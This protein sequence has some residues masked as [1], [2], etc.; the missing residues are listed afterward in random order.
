MR[1]WRELLKSIDRGLDEKL[2]R[3]RRSRASATTSVG[4]AKGAADGPGSPGTIEPTRA[5]RATAHQSAP[6]VGRSATDLAPR[7][8]A[9]VEKIFIGLDWGTHSTKVVIRRDAGDHRGQLLAIQPPPD[10]SRAFDPYSDAP[11][12]WFAI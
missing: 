9:T 2:E 3:F 12:P 10:N 1:N 6:P 7:V 11:Y 8:A 4:G 5:A